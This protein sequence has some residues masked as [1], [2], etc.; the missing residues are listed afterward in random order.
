MAKKNAIF[1]VRV[2]DAAEYESYESHT[3]AAYAVA[4]LVAM[5]TDPDEKIPLGQ[6]SWHHDG[7]GFSLVPRD[8]YDV[9][10]TFEGNNYISAYWG[11]SNADLVRGLNRREQTEFNKALKKAYDQ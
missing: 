11:D 10:P 2:G 4:D 1:W 6:V 9:S 8:P 3:E 7:A 5:M